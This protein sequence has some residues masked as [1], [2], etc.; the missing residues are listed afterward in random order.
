MPLHWTTKRYTPELLQAN[1]DCTFVFGDNLQRVGK[2]GQAIIR[3]EPNVI[4]IPT[5]VTTGLCF[6][7][8]EQYCS[9][10]SWDSKREDY[11]LGWKMYQDVIDKDLLKV[12][13]RL[14]LGE[15]VVVPMDF[16]GTGLARLPNEAPGLL[17][18]LYHRFNLMMHRWGIT[19]EELKEA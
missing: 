16:I 14:A 1:P 15:T 3:D 4:G 7:D 5:K 8:Y 18:Y 9:L 12:E 19:Y 11:Q 13:D 10:P 2:G 6:S 17:F